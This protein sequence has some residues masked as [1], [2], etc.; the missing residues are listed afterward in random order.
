[1]ELD[2]IKRWSSSQALCHPF[3]TRQEFVD[4]WDPP[5]S[6]DCKIIF[7]YCFKDSPF[8]IAQQLFENKMLNKEAMGQVIQSS[9][10]GFVETNQTTIINGE[11]YRPYVQGSQTDKKEGLSQSKNVYLLNNQI[12]SSKLKNKLSLN[13]SSFNV[14]DSQISANN[15]DPAPMNNFFT[16]NSEPNTPKTYKKSHFQ[17]QQLSEKSTLE[18]EEQEENKTDLNH[19]KDNTQRQNPAGERDN[20]TFLSVTH[21]I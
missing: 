18:E 7:F 9:F 12:K 11:S 2:P 6:E 19:G 17:K 10:L 3:I 14:S 1:L 8:P 5:K 20:S 15:S 4:S 16:S 21:I 13:S